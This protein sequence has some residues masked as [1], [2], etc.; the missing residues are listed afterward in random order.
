MNVF[1]TLCNNLYF[2]V[3]MLGELMM[4]HFMLLSANYSVFSALFGTAPLT[5]QQHALCWGIGASTL[6][7]NAIAKKIP[8]DNFM[9][10]IKF[11]LEDERSNDQISRW[12]ANYQDT[13][14]QGQELSTNQDDSELFD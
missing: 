10:T 6:I 3:V 9:F 8:R 11:T 2:W 5:A 14:K 4:Q 1:R 13:L 12:V 7:I